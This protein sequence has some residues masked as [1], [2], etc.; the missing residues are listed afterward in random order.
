MY[1]HARPVRQVQICELE[2]ENGNVMFVVDELSQV[3]IWLSHLGTL[4]E[5]RRKLGHEIGI[6]FLGILP[7]CW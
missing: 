3:Y 1:A 2:L 5:D 4:K 6:Y 7:V